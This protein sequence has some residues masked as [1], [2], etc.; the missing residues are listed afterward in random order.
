MLFAGRR[1]QKRANWG[2]LARH[3]QHA[4]FSFS[5]KVSVTSNHTVVVANSQ[6]QLYTVPQRALRLVHANK[7]ECPVALVACHIDTGADR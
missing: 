1:K 4:M 3:C 2:T 7:P 5:F 6:V